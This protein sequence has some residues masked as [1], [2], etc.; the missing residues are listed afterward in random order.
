[1]DDPASLVDAVVGS[2]AVF[3]VTNCESL[4]PL[5]FSALNI[6]L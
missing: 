1:M 3:A 6:F 4:F 5:K 2:Y